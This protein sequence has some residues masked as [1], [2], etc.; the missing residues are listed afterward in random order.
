MRNILKLIVVILW[1][2]ISCSE[3]PDAGNELT[4]V[5]AEQLRDK[6][7]GGLLGQM[8]GNLNGIPHEMDYIDEPGNVQEYTPALPNGART[9]DDTDFEW[10]YVKVM[11]DEN[12][13]YLSPERMADLWKE[14]INSGIWCS[15]R[16]SRYLMD[17]GIH[18]PLTSNFA[19]N[20]W[21]DF[22][23]SGQ[24]ICETFGL[25]APGMPQTASKI[26]LNFTRI[27][28]DLEPAQTTQLFCTMISTAFFKDDI[29]EILDDGLAALDAKSELREI[30]S[31]VKDWYHQYPQDWRITRQLVKEK[32]TKYNGEMRDRNGYELNTAA[33]IAALLYGDGDFVQTLMTAFNF[34]WDAD[35]T[36]A[37]A[38]TI[39]GVIKGYRWM[40]AQGWK[41]V[42]RY[43]NTKREN[44]PEDETITSFA[45]RVID[46][47]ERIIIN[48]EGKRILKDG[49]PVYMI[50]I[51]KPENVEPLQDMNQKI[52]AMKKTMGPGIKN[53]IA[54]GG[55][56]QDLARSAY[57]AICI[58][59][60]KE[61]KSE[62][63]EN[64][65]KALAALTSY[66][67]VL[68]NIYY[69]DEVPRV[70]PLRE[71]ANAA[72]LKKPPAQRDVW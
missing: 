41:I 28:I 67:K 66:W 16:Y 47:A 2:C 8:L 27:T 64:W 49:N 33:T 40:M 14:R 23:I 62:Y 11:Q 37:T 38:G 42:D 25:M 60:A 55:S 4:E 51:E 59:L 69:D 35:N 57:I 43:H 32:Y 68:Q 44:M 65:D 15:N 70:L 56:E 24:F 21:A 39:V 48:G 72:G 31:D 17:L 20:P 58:D 53:T 22:N 34:G 71:K 63:P 13:I 54:K 7:R 9:D 45:D 10:V 61:L 19:L 52:E 5:S 36:A 1:L 3:V 30:I 6:I 26:G 12:T 18:P 29:N 50:A 46:L